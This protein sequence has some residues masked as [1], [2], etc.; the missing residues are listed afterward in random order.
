MSRIE[1]NPR[2]FV[3][4]LVV[5]LTIFAFA[6]RYPMDDAFISYRYAKFLA[7][8]HGFVWNIG[9]R[10]E[11]YTNFLWTLLLAAGLKLGV[12]PER[13]SIVLSFPFYILA[14]LFTYR[15]AFH[16]TGSAAVGLLTLLFVGFNRSI[17]AFATSGLETTLQM[18]LFLALILLIIRQKANNWDLWG[19]ALLSATSGIALLSR[20]DSAIPVAIA[21][22][23]FYRSGH[24]RDRRRLTAALAPAILLTVPWLIWKTGYYGSL[25]PNSFQVK[26]QG[27]SHILYG[28]FYLHLFALSHVLHA[29]LAIF[30]FHWRSM[31]SLAVGV[32]ESAVLIA[33]WFGYAA[34]VGGDFMEF[35]FLVPILPILLTLLTALAWYFR[36]T[37]ITPALLA[38]LGF[39]TIHSNFALER[40]LHGYGVECVHHLRGHLNGRSENWVLIGQKLKDYFGGSD[41]VVSVG[42]AGAIPYYSEL[43]TIDFLGLTD[44]EIAYNNEPFS[45][46]PGHRVICTLDYLVKRGVN[47]I[48]EPNN[49]MMT[50]QEYGMW[51][52]GVSWREAYQFYLDPDK[53]IRGETIDQIALVAMPVDDEHILIIWYLLPHPLIDKIITEKQWRVFTISRW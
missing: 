1:A 42:A 4:M 27:F 5:I 17:Y 35:R 9:E 34:F 28:M 18:C 20:L 23:V 37:I 49:H 10:V 2:P 29:H 22:F 36:S 53:R 41:V 7:E 51:Q 33:L 21:A 47:I 15:L 43:K 8:G 50:R 14:L 13:F 46:V 6:Q 32:Y 16:F 45:K 31:K 19:T 12:T 3:W 25:L 44:K 39:G 48:V 26:V 11:G 52:R 40:L 38:G 24:W 30:A